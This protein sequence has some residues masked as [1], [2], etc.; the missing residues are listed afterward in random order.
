MSL[1]KDSFRNTSLM[2]AIFVLS[3]VS[4]R[5]VTVALK[6]GEI[7]LEIPEAAAHVDANTSA[8]IS[9]AP[10]SFLK[11]HIARSSSEIDYGTIHTKINTEAAD[12]LMTT[13]GTS[14][15]I[16]CNLDLNRHGG[17]QLTPGRNSLEVDYM[18]HFHRIHYAS[19]LIDR[20]VAAAPH[21]LI[22]SGKPVRVT[23]QKYAVIVGVARYKNSGAGLV[24]LRYADS[25][26][27]GFRDFLISPQGGSFPRDHILTLLNEDATN[28]AVRSALFTFLSKPRPDDFVVIYL[29]GHGSPDPNDSRN[30]YFLTYDTQVDDMGGTAFPMFQFQD[31]FERVLKAR[32]VVTFVDSCHSFGISGEKNLAG[33]HNNLINQYIQRFASNGERAVLTASNTSELSF[34]DTKWG[35]GHGVY[36]YFLLQGL[37]SAADAN[38]DGTVTVAELSTYL[39]D[40]VAGATEGRQNPQAI[41]GGEGNLPVS[42]AGHELAF[43]GTAP[44]HAGR[45]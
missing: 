1:R 38:H 44:V 28:E 12:I 11:L 6:P 45:H 18:D 26:A 37:N 14:D 13:T 8:Q 15:E 34:E 19:F 29:A 22:A 5:S 42:S 4:A 20:G 36:T 3:G 16:L 32:R 40:R 33:P 30:L 39:R 24:N 9:T 7:W 43:L 35:G 31:V 10:L 21:N 23:G 27:T 2:L 41:I 25:D 17:F